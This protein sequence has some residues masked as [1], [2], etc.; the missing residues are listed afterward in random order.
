M[1][2]SIRALQSQLDKSNRKASTAETILKNI[3]QERD[4]AISQLGVA[5]FTIEQLKVENEGLKTENKELK[6][7]LAQLSKDHENETQ[8]WTTKEEALRRKL[9]RRTEAVQSMIEE[10]E[11]QPSKLHD[12]NA[13][14]ARHT[15]V[16][17]RD[18]EASTHKDANTMFDLRPSRKNVNEI[19]KAGQRTVQIDDS[20]DSEDSVYEAPNAKGKGKARSSR[21]A[22]NIHDHETSQN[23]TY[24]SFLEVK[25]SLVHSLQSLTS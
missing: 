11:V 1:E 17:G 21:T 23:L 15:D 12:K 19:S 20:Q 14:K 16:T 13:P 10:T 3:T 9:D 2:S 5:Y 8:K 4:S 22:E 25:T 6:T 18:V 7:R 24:L